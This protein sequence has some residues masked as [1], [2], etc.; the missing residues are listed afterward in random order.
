M[1]GMLEMAVKI[2]EEHVSIHWLNLRKREDTE[3]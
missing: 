2:E 3:N 1:R